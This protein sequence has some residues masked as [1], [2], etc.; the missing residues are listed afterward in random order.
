MNPFRRFIKRLR[1]AERRRYQRIELSPLK[2]KID[3]KRYNT[4]DWSLGG[5]KIGRYH[6]PLASGD[7]VSGRITLEHGA[8]GE[9]VAEVVGVR[10]DGEVAFRLVEITPSIFLAM[11]GIKEA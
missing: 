8:S 9:F 10:E 5:F 1:T 6:V 7:K 11:G 4:V 3:G 2:L